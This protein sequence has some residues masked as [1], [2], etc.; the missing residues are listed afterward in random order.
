MSGGKKRVKQEWKSC[1][2]IRRDGARTCVKI[3][4]HDGKCASIE[5]DWMISWRDEESPVPADPHTRDKF[6][7]YIRGWSDGAGVRAMRDEFTKHA[8][9]ADSYNEGYSDGKK[10]RGVAHVAAAERFGVKL[11]VLRAPGKI[12]ESN[13]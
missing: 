5:G 3:L 1:P 7:A 4:N 11:S 10:S 13:G 6:M 9:L 12:G 8:L 2:K